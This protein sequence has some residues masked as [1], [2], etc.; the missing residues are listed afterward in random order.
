MKLFVII[1]ILFFALFYQHN[2]ILSKKSNRLIINSDRNL[3]IIYNF[4]PNNEFLILKKEI[5]QNYKKYF[6]RRNSIIRK[7]GAF[8]YIDTINTPFNKIFKSLKNLKTLEKIQKEIGLELQFVPAT[9]PNVISLLIYDKEGDGINWHKD[10]SEYYG[11][12]WAG[13]YTIVNTNNKNGFSSSDF[14][15]QKDNKIFK[16]NTFENSLLI[17]KGN[18]IYHKISKLKKGEK[19][20]VISM[21]FCDVCMPI[22]DIFNIIKQ[23]IINLSFYG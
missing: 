5:L 9:D 7:G 21:L 20:I 14:L 1:F 19:R 17:F 10:S 8:S 11:N 22:F 18:E 15:Y 3:Y 4:I 12:R 6:T 16:I 13:I 23:K 2:Y